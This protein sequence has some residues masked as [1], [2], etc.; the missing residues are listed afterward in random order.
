MGMG[1]NGQM[2]IQQVD[3]EDIVLTEL[4]QHQ[5]V[6]AFAVNLITPDIAC[7]F[8]CAYGPCKKSLQALD[9]KNGLEFQREALDFQNKTRTSKCITAI[10]HAVEG[11]CCMICCAINCAGAIMN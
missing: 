5:T 6:N 2:V 9:D 1:P 10:P 8:L 3:A 4:I 11:V 7:C